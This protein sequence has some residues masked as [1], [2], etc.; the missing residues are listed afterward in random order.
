MRAL[1]DL[2]FGK[3][4][5]RPRR[6]RKTNGSTASQRPRGRKP[7]IASSPTEA[8][9]RL[10]ETIAREAADYHDLEVRLFDVTEQ[11]SHAARLEWWSRPRQEVGP[12]R[13]VVH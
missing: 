4:R 1:L 5:R 12:A 2:L 3:D 6:R 8:A 10:G 7:D 9:R 11:I 13:K